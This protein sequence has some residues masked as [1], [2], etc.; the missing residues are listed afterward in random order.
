MRNLLYLTILWLQCLCAQA[1]I[2]A[3]NYRFYVDE[4]RKM[5]VCNQLPIPSQ[6]TGSP[7]QMQFGSKVFTFA[8]NVTTLSYGVK[9]LITN[10]G[11]QYSL[12]FTQLPLVNL[13]VPDPSQ[14]NLEEEIPGGISIAEPTTS[15]LV[16][17]MAIRIRGNSSSFFPKKN[18]RVQF[19]DAQGKNKDQSILGLRSDKRWLFFGMWNEEL[20]STNNVSHNLWIDMHKLYYAASEP[21]AV[22]SIRTKYVEVF[23]NKSYKGVYMIG[24]DMDRKQ[25]QLKKNDGDVTRGELFK[26]DDWSL[27]AAWEGI[28]VAKP[29]P[30]AEDWQ[31]WELEYPDYSDWNNHHNLLKA[32]IESSDADFKANIWNLF[33]Q[34][35]V[36]DYFIFL[37]LLSVED[38]MEKNYFIGRYDQ[39]QP[40]FFVPWDLDGAWGYFPDGVRSNK[41]QGDRQ[42][43]LFKKLFRTNPDGFK[44]KLATRYFQLRQNLLA[45]ANLKNRFQTNYN[46]LNSNLIYERDAAVSQDNYGGANRSGGL[47]YVN[48]YITQRLAWLDTYFCPMMDGGCNGQ[49]SCAFDITATASNTSPACSANVT[50][51]SGCTGADCAGVI[52]T[53]SGNGINQTGSSINITAPGANGSYTYTV[54]ASKSGCADKTAT[55]TLNITNCNPPVGNDPFSAC[56]EAENQ[57]G[58]GAITGDPN[59][60]NG[61]TRGEKD[62]YNHYVDYAVNGVKV[63]GTHQV[64]VRYYANGAAQASFSVNGSVVLPS[65]NFPPTYSWNIVWREET[66]NVTLNQGNNTLRIQ[67][68]SGYS[69]RQDKICVTGPGGQNPQEPTCNFNIAPSANK[70]TYAPQEQISF[71]ANCTGGD[72]GSVTYAWTG[73][74]ANA[75]GSTANINAPSAPGSYTYTLTA[76]KNG[77]ANKTV[78]VIIQVANS[79]PSC[80]F[81]ITA[82]ASNTSPACSANVTLS[83]GCTGADCAGVIYTWTGNGINQTGSS[84]NITAPGANG[85]YTY[86]VKASKSGCA[87]KTATVTL[88]ITN[89]NPPVGN[90]PFSACL[91][92]ESQSGNGAITGDPNASNGSTRGE[93]DNYNHYV[94]YAVNGVKATGTHQVKVRYYA[95]GAAQASFSVNGNVVLPSANFPPTYSWNIVWREETFNVTLNQGNNTL[96]IQGLPGYSIRQDKICVTGPGGQNPQEPTCNF[97][98][99]PSANKATYA[100]QEQISFN[101]NCTG[102]DCGSVAYA[103]TGNGANASGSTANINAPSAPGSY[104]Y[105]LTATKN[106]CANKTVNVTIQ[107]SNSQPSCAFDIT[108]TASNNSPA[109]SANVTLSSGCTGA[110]C[111]GVIYTWTGNGINQTGSS[112]NITAPGANGSYTYTVKAS[113]SGCVDKTA[114]VTLNI[115]NCNPPVG[116]NFS[117]CLESESQSGN[118]AITGDPNASNGSTRGAKEDYNHYVDYAVNGVPNAGVYQLKLRY[119]ASSNPNI[120]ISVNGNTAI[121]LVN[122]T[123]TY[124]WNIVFRE[125]VFN[126]TLAA[127]NNTVRIQGLSGP[128]IRQDKLCVSGTGSNNARMGAP[129]KLFGPAAPDESLKVF[130][131]PSP[132]EFNAK[133][134]LSD[135]NEGTITV[136]DIRGRVWHTSK[137]K[138]NGAHDEQ[139]KLPNVPSGIYLIQIK[140]GKTTEVKK[141]LIGQ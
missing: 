53:W 110:D 100:P 108:A 119:S 93:K 50:L 7:I 124:T 140:N 130:P 79:Q 135:G 97:N 90:D 4:G 91:E 68:L 112:I 115:T 49:S 56:F 120:A 141:L 117:L 26:A 116:G 85:S 138:G 75:S 58:N 2:P 10:D 126:V 127:G 82:T 9:Y 16:S 3:D 71:N 45:E 59:A 123:A 70:A 32:V 41:T 23:M 6:I 20:R 39:G 44:N 24:E 29:A 18:Y 42:N 54:K 133:F 80:A 121:A 105:T 102:G 37:N 40:W 107:V 106:G 52:Y 48:N 62:N 28:G 21:S 83:S 63:T 5:I 76:T 65:A 98:I 31:S 13:E 11:Q 99:A 34:E 33:K 36:I 139:I 88:N 64:K 66:F 25:L 81:D 78:N 89:C 69:I 57:S 72:C 19:K 61:S 111:A 136:T 96:R 125:E 103:W 132:G 113:K 30:G 43:G 15:P 17:N 134:S 86:T 14:I 92:A 22:S 12:Y 84:I 46:L 73:N 129:E 35:N 95:N 1:Q 51:S 137:V 77:C 118:G 94:D 8:G 74:G 67:G 87:D 122:V 128:S 101:A 131:N 47:A 27:S 38:N 55:V 109:C 114:T 104:T 60:S